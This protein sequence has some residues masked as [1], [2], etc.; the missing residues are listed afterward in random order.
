M[1]GSSHVLIKTQSSK[2]LLNV[3]SYT[4]CVRITSDILRRSL[5]YESF[6]EQ[7]DG[8]DVED[9]QIEDV[10]TIL[11]Q[12][13]CD[14]VPF[15][16]QPVAGSILGRFNMKARHSAGANKHR[17]LDHRLRHSARRPRRT[18]FI[19]TPA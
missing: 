15:F 5:T 12:E 9:E 19:L 17:R 1:E 6:D 4:G 10:L 18:Y 16:Q 2:I 8:D 11:L 3:I 14:A 7:G 13:R